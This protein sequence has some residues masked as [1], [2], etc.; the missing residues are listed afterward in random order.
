[1]RSNGG[2]AARRDD[3]D[4][5]ISGVSS[6]G[7]GLG[8]QFGFAA[9]GEEEDVGVG[10]RGCCC[11]CCCA[12]RFVTDDVAWLA[13]RPTCAGAGVLGVVAPYSRGVDGAG[14]D[15]SAWT[16]RY[17]EHIGQVERVSKWV[18]MHS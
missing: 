6:P 18:V 7:L 8:L 4:V 15:C 1:M 2:G 16:V 3:I 5:V 10:V 13:A 11:C 17:V 9:T 14:S 12:T